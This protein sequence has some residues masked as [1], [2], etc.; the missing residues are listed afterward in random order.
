MKQQQPPVPTISR[1]SDDTI[2]A[3]EQTDYF[4]EDQPPVCLRIGDAAA[5]HLA[6][7]DRHAAHSASILTA[8]NPFGQELAR[9]ENDALQ[10]RLQTTI[11]HSGLNWLPARLTA[12]LLMLGAPAAL[13]RRLPAE[14][15]R[16]PSPNSGWPMSAMALRLGI[17]LGKPGVYR[18]ND[19]APQ[20][21]SAHTPW[22]IR[23]AQRVTWIAVLLGMFFLVLQSMR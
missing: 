18:L 12:A 22:A 15:R 4:A 3:Y 14:A 9:A 7:L 8:W 10:A 2:R 21:E 20:P 16:T 11:L 19:V 23:K 6:W 1:P 5:V 17:T 13:W